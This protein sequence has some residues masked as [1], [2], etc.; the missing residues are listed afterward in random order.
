[1]RF[2]I[3]SVSLGNW[4]LVG[5]IIKY[6]CFLNMGSHI[7]LTDLRILR[8]SQVSNKFVGSFYTLLIIMQLLLYISIPT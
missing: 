2:V 8:F 6:V 4:K 1:M 5:C 3:C 7:A